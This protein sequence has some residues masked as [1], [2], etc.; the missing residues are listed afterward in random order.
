MGRATLLLCL[1]L[2]ACATSR[3]ACLTAATREVLRLDRL[4]AETDGNLRR[5]YAIE[6]GTA[7]VTLCIG[8]DG[9]DA[10]VTPPARERAVAIDPVVERRKLAEL[11]RARRRAAARAV[12]DQAA[13][14]A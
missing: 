12:Q 7:Q 14:P 13:C 5:G 10:C 11:K 4:I 6:Q 8:D 3:Q 2:A 1:V 9:V